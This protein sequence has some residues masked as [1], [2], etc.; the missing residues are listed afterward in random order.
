MRITFDGINYFD[1]DKNGNVWLPKEGN[2]LVRGRADHYGECNKALAHQLKNGEWIFAEYYWD[3]IDTQ[4]NGCV[5]AERW[6]QSLDDIKDYL[7][8]YHERPNYTKL[9]GFDVEWSE[10]HN[11][12]ITPVIEKLEEELWY[13][14]KFTPEKVCA[15]HTYLKQGGSVWSYFNM[16]QIKIQEYDSGWSKI[17]AK[18]LKDK[19]IAKYG[20][21][22]YHWYVNNRIG[23]GD[24]RIDAL[25]PEVIKTI[26][27][28][29]V[30]ERTCAFERM[31]EIY[32]RRISLDVL[33]A[34]RYPAEEYAGKPL[35]YGG[36]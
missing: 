7:D 10:F 28:Q 19:I 36:W 15:Y 22:L 6:A 34:E 29:V 11:S 18:I 31:T 32:A 9:L 1:A 27:E 5:R 16:D 35:Y 20:Y 25:K 2:V 12:E 23:G 33:T 26:K 30:A 24:E 13:G 21:N 14:F 17:F 3:K 8:I 4:S